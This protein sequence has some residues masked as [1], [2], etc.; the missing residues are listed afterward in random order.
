M[1]HKKHLAPQIVMI[2]A[3]DNSEKTET[4]NTDWD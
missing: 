3:L 1:T 2:W 4:N